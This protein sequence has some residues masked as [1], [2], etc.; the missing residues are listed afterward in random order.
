[1]VHGRFALEESAV[2]LLTRFLR[3]QDL[4]LIGL[5]LDVGALQPTAVELAQDMD[6]SKLYKLLAYSLWI[7]SWKPDRLPC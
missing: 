3:A 1:M 6:C 7:I 2:I 5:V 4:S